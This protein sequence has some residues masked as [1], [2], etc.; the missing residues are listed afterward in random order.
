MRFVSGSKS[1]SKLI[2]Y[3]GGIPRRSLGKTSENS[4]T[5]GTESMGGIS[6]SRSWTLTIWYRQSLEITFH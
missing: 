1:M 2:S 5:T 4:L 6:E 3:S